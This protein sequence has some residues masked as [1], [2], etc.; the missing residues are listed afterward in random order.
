MARLKAFGEALKA[1]YGA[2]NNL[3]R[4]HMYADP[5]VS[6]AL[7]NNQDTFWSAPEGSPHAVLEVDFAQPI[8]FDHALTME[9]LNDGQCI[10]EY[11]IDVWE[12][13]AWTSVAKAEAIGH[14]KIDR[15]PAVTAKKVRLNVL[16]SAC[17]AR[18]REFQLFRVGKAR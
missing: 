9:W 13:N 12:D 14:M 3:M 5:N 18:I 1:R 16:S 7:D 10:Q 6:A 8:T 15:F 17:T 11:A 4:N 2:G